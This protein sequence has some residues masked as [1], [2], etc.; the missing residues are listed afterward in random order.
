MTS[1]IKPTTTTTKTSRLRAPQKPLAKPLVN[2]TR[3]NR[4]VSSEDEGNRKVPVVRHTLKSAR[5]TKPMDKK[6]ALSKRVN[7]VL[8][9]TPA[10]RPTSTS[11]TV[12]KVAALSKSKSTLSTSR[13]AP[14]TSAREARI[15]KINELEAKCASLATDNKELSTELDKYKE[16]YKHLGT[17]KERLEIRFHD[18]QKQFEE[19]LTSAQVALT[20]QVDAL[21]SEI[22]D[23]DV[24]ITENR[25]SQEKLQTCH[26]KILLDVAALSNENEQNLTKNA[27]LHEK[28]SLLSSE[29]SKNA[30]DISELT[31]ER[32][33]LDAKNKNLEIEISKTC[34]EL[35]L[36]TEEFEELKNNFNT[37]MQEQ[38][39]KQLEIYKNPKA[40]I[41]SLQSVLDMK[42]DRIHTLGEK[43]EETLEKIRDMEDLKTENEKL[44]DTEKI[45]IEEKQTMQASCDENELLI[46]DQNNLIKELRQKI[47]DLTLKSEE[48]TYRLDNISSTESNSTVPLSKIN[49]DDVFNEQ[50][51]SAKTFSTPTSLTSTTKI[52]QEPPRSA[53]IP[54][55]RRFNPTYDPSPG[56]M[57]TSISGFGSR[58]TLNEENNFPV[59][60][61]G[62]IILRR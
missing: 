34:S 17:A 62:S 36:V 26:D 60:Y 21:K 48:L 38:Y 27:L 22:E 37:K 33:S 3:D 35:K 16:L 56:L 40:E 1:I 44:R 61:D 5:E 14:P 4:K 46:Q 59:E 8:A 13:P 18:Q 2:S 19:E 43:L 50:V 10:A 28:I 54:T 25:I 24:K 52:K 30:V 23:R 6:P 15:Q 41:D 45:L 58:Q 47:T 51:E 7:A 12:N 39:E 49:F 57:N 29:L 55:R 42:Q 20:A 31:A 32:D 53:E 9:K 11:S